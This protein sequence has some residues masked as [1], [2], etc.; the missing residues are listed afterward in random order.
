M[1]LRALYACF[2]PLI[3]F[4]YNLILLDTFHMCKGQ[5]VLT[6]SVQFPAVVLFVVRKLTVGMKLLSYSTNLK[7]QQVMP[8]YMQLVLKY[9]PLITL[10]ATQ[11]TEKYLTF[12]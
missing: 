4:M 1:V 11:H 12:R 2:S 8:K 3:L 6:V 10:N 7:N 5:L 9:S